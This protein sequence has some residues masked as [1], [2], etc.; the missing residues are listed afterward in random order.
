MEGRRLSGYTLIREVGRGGMGSVYLAERSDGAF[1]KQA[2]IKLAFGTG[3]TGLIWEARYC[4]H[5][6]TG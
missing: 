6:A 3:L 1:R 4:L 5:V 2:A